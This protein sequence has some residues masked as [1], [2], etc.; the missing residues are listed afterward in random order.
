M[1]GIGQ[2]KEAEKVSK[3]VSTEKAEDEIQ[4]D[5]EEDDNLP[6]DDGEEFGEGDLDDESSLKTHRKGLPKRT[7]ILIGLLLLIGLGGG[8][9]IFLNSEEEPPPPPPAPVKKKVAVAPV[10]VTAPVAT[11]PVAASP[12][13][14]AKA[15]KSSPST[16]TTVPVA[17]TAV[18]PVSVST[19]DKKVTPS[20]VA[21]EPEAVVNNG[22]LVEA[23]PQPFFLSA[24]AY[25]TLKN[26]RAVEKKLRHLGYSPKIETVNGMVPMTRLLLGVYS[27]EEADAKKREMISQIPDLFP[28]K[29]GEQIALYAGSYQSIDQARKYADELYLRG[30]HAEEESVSLR[31]PLKKI[32]YGAFATRADA[33]KAAK[34]AVAAGIIA[35]VNKR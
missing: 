20:V 24:G 25:A 3:K 33:E 1:F 7:A 18:T 12:T 9:Y 10:A 19:T 26:Q 30:I 23:G 8:G 11:A 14:A 15:D 32:T 31:L 29:R 2:K 13:S 16:T 34:K 5:F 4:F 17:K 6:F 27:P 22:S 28:L 21:K 35:E